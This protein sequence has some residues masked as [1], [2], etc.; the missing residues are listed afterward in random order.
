[1]KRRDFLKLGSI[2]PAAALSD[3][4][5][6][7]G[8]LDPTKKYLIVVRVDDDHELL[9]DDKDKLEQEIERAFDQIGIDDQDIG[10][11]ILEGLSMEIMEVS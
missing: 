6:D 10:I 7:V 8:E 11:I 2:L 3:F 9:P 4:D 5:I 1:M